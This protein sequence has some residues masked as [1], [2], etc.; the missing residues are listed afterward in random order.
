MLSN[1]STTEFREE[2]AREILAAKMRDIV[3]EPIRA[4]DAESWQEYDRRTSTASLTWILVKEGWAARWLIDAKPSELD[5]WA[6]DH[7]AEVE[8]AVQERMSDDAPKA[9]H[10]RHVLVKT[11][12]GASDEEKSLAIAKVS[13]A[14]SRIRAGEAFAEVARDLSEDTGSAIKGGDVGDKTD[15]F[16]APFRVAAEALKPGEATQGAVETQ[17]GY[18]LIMRDDPAQASEIE[19]QVKRGVPRTLLSKARASDAAREVAQRIVGAMR[20]GKTPEDA[21]TEVTAAYGRLD[22]PAA[23]VRILKLAAEN[24][25]AADAGVDASSGGRATEKPPSL[26]LEHP[27]LPEK[28]FGA[29]SDPDRPQVQTSAAFNRGG[30]PFPGLTPEGTATVV[31][32]AFSS[33]DGDAMA[34]PVR[35]PDG[36]VAVVLKQ[37]KEATR[38]DF[39]KDRDAIQEDMVR[40]KRDEALALYVKRLREEAKAAIKVD[41]SYVQEASVDGGA[42]GGGADEDEDQY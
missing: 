32:F 4:S 36:Y 2:Q 8:K 33:K 24:G 27:G 41:E 14:A 42:G 16:V 20:A 37:R 13:W 9:G 1:R 7:Q 5:A 35:T 31:A 3:R 29:A 40:S 18:H 30:D 15:G 28:P 6:K 10:L 25:S 19:A 38:A 11:P 34:E 22:K 26:E 23:P 17:F 12:Y 39:D 21:V